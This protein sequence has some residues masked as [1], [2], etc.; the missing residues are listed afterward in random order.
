LSLILLVAIG[1]LVALGLVNR[2]VKPHQTANPNNKSG[3]LSTVSQNKSAQK[4][5]RTAKGKVSKSKVKS[6]NK[7]ARKLNPDSWAGVTSTPLY[8]NT[9]SLVSAIVKQNKPYIL[10]RPAGTY[11]SPHQISFNLEYTISAE[12]ITNGNQER[13]FIMSTDPDELLKVGQSGSGTFDNNQNQLP[14][15]NELATG[16]R[17]YFNHSLDLV[18]EG[19]MHSYLYPQNGDTPPTPGLFF[20]TVDGVPQLK[21]GVQIYP[22]ALTAVNTIK[23]TTGSQYSLTG[24]TLTGGMG[25]IDSNG[26]VIQEVTNTASII[27]GGNGSVTLTAAAG[28]AAY[29]AAQAGAVGSY[30]W[31][32][33]SS[34]VSVTYTGC[35]LNTATYTSPLEYRTYSLWDCV[36]PSVAL[37]AQY[38]G[39]ELWN[40]TGLRFLFQNLT[41]EGSLAGS[42]LGARLP[43]YSANKIPGTPAGVAALLSSQKHHK[44]MENKL[45]KGACYVYTPEKVQDYF[46]RQPGGFHDRP[47]GVMYIKPAQLFEAGCSLLIAVTF[48]YE[49]ITTDVSA[50]MFPSASSEILMNSILYALSKENGWSENPNHLAHA[51]QMVKKVMTSDEMKYALKS[52]ISA[53]VKIAPMVVSALM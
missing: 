6:A 30:F 28:W 4:S 48:S 39:C 31:V 41:P 37:K 19:E 1:V 22:F 36:Q 25:C 5:K 47:F 52:L 29:L 7:A 50:T 33:V 20:H 40:A 32:S 21:S 12:D 34:D 10:P 13:V 53:G 43:S 51:A 8:K 44:L 38:Q 26:D 3:A 18:N 9:E 35:E 24:Y 17:Y 11:V 15:D 2:S 14:L 49:L 42:V 23:L 16:P 45:S 46:F 27:S